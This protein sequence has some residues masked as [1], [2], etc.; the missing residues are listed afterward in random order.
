MGRYEKAVAS[1]DKALEYK[2]DYYFAWLDKASLQSRMGRGKDAIYSYDKVLEIQPNHYGACHRR[3]VVLSMIDRYEEAM[4]GFKKAIEL[5]TGRVSAISWAYLGVTLGRLDRNEESLVYFEKAIEITSGKE[6]FVWCG[7]VIPLLKLGR[8]K[9]AFISIYQ[10]FFSVFSGLD[11]GLIER[12]EQRIAI[13]LT[14]LGLRKLVPV[15]TRF[16]HSIGWKF[17]EW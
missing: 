9:D 16:L 17:K 2:T 3:A 5:K 15:W 13:Q 12:V 1:Y 11:V 7:Q 4:I 10:C 8:F 6:H 14:K